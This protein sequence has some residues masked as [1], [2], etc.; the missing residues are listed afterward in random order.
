MDN[1]QQIIQYLEEVATILIELQVTTP[2]YMLI[3]GG[4]YM[5][6]NQKRRFTEDIDF[7]LVEKPQRVPRKNRVFRVTVTHAEVFRAQSIV[8]FSAEFRQA[9]LLVAQRHLGLA[10]DWLND[11]AAEYYYDDAPQPDVTFWRSFQDILHVYLPTQGYVFATK[12]AASRPKDE[13][14]IRILM[15]DLNIT[16]RSQA[17]A[18]IDRFLLPDAQAFWQ[19]EENLDTLF[20]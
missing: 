1:D 19:V 6:L 8:P 12:I 4:A 5:L 3:T 14:D 9:V 10:K 15:Q 7:A 2:F 20:P 13:Q 11:E 18:I 17:K 16:T